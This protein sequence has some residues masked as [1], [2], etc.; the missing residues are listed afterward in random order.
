MYKRPRLDPKDPDWKYPYASRQMIAELEKYFAHFATRQ[1]SWHDQTNNETH[2]LDRFRKVKIPFESAPPHLRQRAKEWFDRKAA[3][4]I[5]VN[6]PMHAGKYRSLMMNACHVA[7]T[8]WTSRSFVQRLHYFKSRK[9]WLRY[10]HWKAQQERA[11][12]LKQMG[13]AP[14]RFLEVS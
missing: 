10:L 12:M 11:E 6:G 4:W 2:I 5:A 9:K 8:E 14:N 3:E 13:P 7:R 1:R